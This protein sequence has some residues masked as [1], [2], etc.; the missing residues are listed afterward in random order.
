M[1]AR[2]PGILS[3]EK[4]GFLTTAGAGEAF[5]KV[6]ASREVEALFIAA[7]GAKAAAEPARR[8]ARASFMIVFIGWVKRKTG[9]AVDEI[10]AFIL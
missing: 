2:A 6:T 7:G 8:E 5:L 1:G 4:E 3:T 9:C 10:D